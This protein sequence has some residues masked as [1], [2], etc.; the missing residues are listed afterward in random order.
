MKRRTTPMSV[1]TK[2]ILASIGESRP[3]AAYQ[4]DLNVIESES[5]QLMVDIM[6]GGT[7]T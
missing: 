6:Q 3:K 7:R 2:R 4:D 1:A 5:R